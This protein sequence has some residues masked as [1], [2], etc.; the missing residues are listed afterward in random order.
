M[1]LYQFKAKICWNDYF[2]ILGDLKQKVE[3]RVLKR[4]CFVC[5]SF[6][7]LG[8]FLANY[9]RNHFV[10]D[11]KH[12]A[13]P[14]TLHQLRVFLSMVSDK[15]LLTFDKLKWLFVVKDFA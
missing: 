12:V 11:R 1:V 8:Q 10:E 14:W 6:I 5:H 13:M 4:L 15:L 7:I 2:A 9:V 3:E